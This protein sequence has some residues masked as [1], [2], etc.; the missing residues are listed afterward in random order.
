[1]ILRKP[2]RPKHR[3]LIKAGKGVFVLHGTSPDR[4]PDDLCG[5]RR[6]TGPEFSKRKAELEAREAE[7]AK[8]QNA[9]AVSV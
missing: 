4:D 1:M 9:I 6:L 8:R 2:P 3:R 7:A 5:G